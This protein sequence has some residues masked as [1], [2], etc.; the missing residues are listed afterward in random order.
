MSPAAA[1][2]LALALASCSALAAAALELALACDGK[3]QRIWA[4]LGRWQQQRGDHELVLINTDGTVMQRRS[5]KPWTVQAGTPMQWDAVG[6]QLLLTLSQAGMSDGRAALLDAD[7]LQTIDI[8]ADPIGE[9][10]WLQA[11]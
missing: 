6:N 4:V 8:G 9:A 5:L 3:G 2:D 7:N 11:G 10:Q 1:P